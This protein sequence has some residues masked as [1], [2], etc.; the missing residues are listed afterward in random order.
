MRSSSLRSPRLETPRS[1][2]VRGGVI[3]NEVS[4]SY[5]VEIFLS[6]E[7]VV[8]HISFSDQIAVF[9]RHFLMLASFLMETG[10]RLRENAFKSP[11]I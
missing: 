3:V 9:R 6:D 11:G 4:R 8:L 10:G 1:H 7:D 5:G 2:S